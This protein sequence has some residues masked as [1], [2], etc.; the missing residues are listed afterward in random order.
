MQMPTGEASI[1]D[2][3]SIY[4]I[5]DDTC[6]SVFVRRCGDSSLQTKHGEGVPVGKSTDQE[7]HVYQQRSPLAFRLTTH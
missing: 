4:S 5:E 2:A 7:I 3:Y 6:V 1:K